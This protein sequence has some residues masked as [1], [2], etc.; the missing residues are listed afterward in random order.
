[1]GLVGGYLLN[2]DHRGGVQVPVDLHH[3]SQGDGGVFA[4]DHGITQRH[5]AIVVVHEISTQPD[6]VSQALGTALTGVEEAGVTLDKRKLGQQRL[7]A[8]LLQGR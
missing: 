4:R 6:G 2:S 5:H 7:I 1:M 3:S 8:G